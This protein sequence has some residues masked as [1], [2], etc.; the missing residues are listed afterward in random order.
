LPE[1]EMTDFVPLNE[2]YAMWAENMSITE[3]EHT[4]DPKAPQI[5]F[6]FPINDYEFVFVCSDGVESFYHPIRN[7]VQKSN[8]PIFVLD[9]LRVLLDFPARPGFARLQRN[10]VFKQDRKGTFIRRNWKNGD[11]LSVGAIHNE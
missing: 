8:E 1:L 10:W 9:A 3:K 5:S 11:D 4:L 2:R 7:D 6:D